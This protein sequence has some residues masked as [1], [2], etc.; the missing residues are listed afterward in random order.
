M[1]P[2]RN[3]TVQPRATLHPP[4]TKPKGK[5]EFEVQDPS[6]FAGPPTWMALHSAATT[7]EPSQRQGFIAL[8][9][10]IEMTFPCGRCRA[11][12]TKHLKELPLERYLGNRDE[13]FLWT[14]LMHDKVN[15]LKRVKS[16]PLNRVKKYYFETLGVEC[17][18]CE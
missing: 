4:P 6:V 1:Y 18:N 11:N 14:Y 17:G 16:P 8:V 9:K 5:R 15:Q 10:G 3:K 2:A 7:Y 13:V 12:F